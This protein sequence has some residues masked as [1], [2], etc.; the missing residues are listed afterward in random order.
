[1]KSNF[2]W[3]RS[4]TRLIGIVLRMKVASGPWLVSSSGDAE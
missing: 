2:K 1:M 3:V 4:T